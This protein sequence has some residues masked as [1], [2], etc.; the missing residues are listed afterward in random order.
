MVTK[1]KNNNLFRKFLNFNFYFCTNFFG[2][3]SMKKAK[4][5]FP[6]NYVKTQEFLDIVF[7]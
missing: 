7:K 2:K 4:K 6:P 1:V 5:N 3:N